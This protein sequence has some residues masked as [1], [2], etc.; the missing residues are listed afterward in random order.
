MSKCT[1]LKSIHHPP[2][3]KNCGGIETANNGRLLPEHEGQCYHQPSLN[4]NEE[5]VATCIQRE[6]P[7]VC[8]G[9]GHM[10]TEGVATCIQMEMYTEGVATHTLL[11]YCEDN[12][13]LERAFG[14]AMIK[15]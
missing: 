9:S 1:V 13:A 12:W 2:P 7:H 4:C 6:W 8:R 3:I 5:G 10:Y 15:G 11:S 14:R